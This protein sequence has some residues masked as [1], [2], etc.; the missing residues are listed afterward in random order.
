MSRGQ[1]IAAKEKTGI[2]ADAECKLS[3]E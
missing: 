2:D 3:A 1:V